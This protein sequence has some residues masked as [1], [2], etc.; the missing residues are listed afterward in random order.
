MRLGPRQ[1]PQ[2]EVFIDWTVI[3]D[4]RDLWSYGR[5]TTYRL[6][7]PEQCVEHLHRTSVGIPFHEVDRRRRWHLLRQLHRGSLR[8]RHFTGKHVKTPGAEARKHPD[9]GE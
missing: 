9:I 8:D 6:L 5:K 4:W 1:P 2:K 3:L 7:D